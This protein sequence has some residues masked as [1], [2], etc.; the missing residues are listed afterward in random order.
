MNPNDDMYRRIAAQLL[1][2]EP[3]DVTPQQRAFVKWCSFGARGEDDARRCVEI[4]LQIGL[5]IDEKT[6]K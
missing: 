1:N 5:A 4:A 6:R 2:I 3:E